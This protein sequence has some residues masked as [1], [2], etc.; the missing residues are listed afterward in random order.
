MTKQVFL[1]ELRKKLRGLPERDIEDRLTFY[2]EMIDDRKEEGLSEAEAVAAIGSIDQIARQAIADTPLIKIAQERIRPKRSLKAWEITLLAVGSPVWLSLAI[3]A[4]AVLCAVYV[5]L[6]S[7]VAALWAAFGA[8]AVGSVASVPVCVIFIAGG[9]G[10]SGVAL[11]AAGM[12]CAGFAILTFYGCMATTKGIIKLTKAI[13]VWV[14][15]LVIKK[16][17]A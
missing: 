1:A 3:A 10:A 13:A 9:S 11:L 7:V 8:F 6:W 5:S 4:V 12:V 16:E 14:K 17:E 15:M 2:D